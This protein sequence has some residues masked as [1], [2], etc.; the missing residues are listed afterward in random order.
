MAFISKVIKQALKGGSAPVTGNAAE[1]DGQW[2]RGIKNV[3][4]KRNGQASQTGVASPVQ[5]QRS[6]NYV[7]YV[8]HGTGGAG[9]DPLARPPMSKKWV[10]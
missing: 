4:E 9:F 8:D 10:E 2:K 3:V 6:N 1:R 7:D 5:V